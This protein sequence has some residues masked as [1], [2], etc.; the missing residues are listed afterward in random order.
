MVQFQVTEFK[1]VKR[2]I[3]KNQV[4]EQPFFLTYKL[5]NLQIVELINY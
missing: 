2:Y 4:V 5:Q 3:V 1:V